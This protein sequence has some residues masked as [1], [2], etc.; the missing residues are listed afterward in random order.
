MLPDERTTRSDVTTTPGEMLGLVVAP[1]RE[2]A[3]PMVEF[4]RSQAIQVQLFVDADAALEEALLHPPDVILIDDGIGPAGGVE[5]AQRLKNNSRTHVVPLCLWGPVADRQFRLRALAAGA[6]SIYSAESDLQEMRTRLWALL[7]TRALMRRTQRKQDRKDATIDQQRRWVGAFVHDL[8][9]TL[10]AMR[11]NHEFLA[12]KI[13]ATDADTRECLFD[14]EVLYADIARGL[15]CVLDYER[16]EI[17]QLSCSI[18][19]MNVS[20]LLAQVSEAL[21]KQA[22]SNGKNFVLK[23][24]RGLG[25]IE[26]DVRLLQAALICLG[27]HIL[28]HPVNDSATISVELAGEELQISI[29]GNGDFLS[30]EDPES[31][32][33]PY[34]RP[35]QAGTPVGHGV[36]LALARA[37]FSMHET[38][39]RLSTVATGTKTLPRFAIEFPRMGAIPVGFDA[40]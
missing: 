22:K 26:G 18:A 21:S 27:S 38:P 33:V 6:D 14:S 32:F 7:K 37:I 2:S 31:L 8:Q 15:R 19:P 1:D 40:E 12:Q 23:A 25:M 29:F 10:A 24:E 5:L 20:N 13:Q 36:G 3:R 28:R 4:L 34:G 35:R 16:F 11:A 30:N 39:L 9:S 17:G